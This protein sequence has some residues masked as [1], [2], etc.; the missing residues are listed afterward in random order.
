MIHHAARAFLFVALG[1]V[2]TGCWARHYPNGLRVWT[3]QTIF[4]GKEPAHGHEAQRVY[5]TDKD[6]RRH[7]NLPHEL[8]LSNGSV[9]KSMTPLDLAKLI[10]DA[11]DTF[12][13]KRFNVGE[14][15]DMRKIQVGLGPL[16]DDI[17]VPALINAFNMASTFEMR[18]MLREGLPWQVSKITIFATEIPEK[19]PVWSREMSENPDRPKQ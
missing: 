9:V 1:L 16:E 14:F 8:G 15:S 3:P 18:P 10:A 2:L 5:D 17:T 6:Y 4:P 13:D 7:V 11:G 19:A 12:L